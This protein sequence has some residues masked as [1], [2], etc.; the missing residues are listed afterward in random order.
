MIFS[1]IPIVCKGY[2]RNLRP[3]LLTVTS[4]LPLDSLTVIY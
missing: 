1:T 4:L 2:Y 3:A